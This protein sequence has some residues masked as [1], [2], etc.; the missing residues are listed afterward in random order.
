MFDG[1]SDISDVTSRLITYVGNVLGRRLTSIV[2]YVGPNKI[3]NV[4]NSLLYIIPD[5][6]DIPTTDL[7]IEGGLSNEFEIKKAYM[8]IPF[9]LSLQSKKHRLNMTN[10]V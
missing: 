6:V 2:K 4:I 8:S 10:N 5:E 9:D 3:A 1:I 7:Y